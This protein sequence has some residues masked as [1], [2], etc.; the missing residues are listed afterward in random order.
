MRPRFSRRQIGLARELGILIESAQLRIA[1]AADAERIAL[2][3]AIGER[4]R[5][6]FPSERNQ[7]AIADHLAAQFGPQFRAERLLL[8]MQLSE[9]YPIREMGPSLMRKLTWSHFI[10]L[11]RIEGPSKR[12]FYTDRCRVE[13]LSV[14]ALRKEINAGVYERRVGGCP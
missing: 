4:L 10:Q 5:R 6:H 11:I 7:S 13:Q 2:Y 12:K 14:G 3:W 9:K 1:Q 8:M